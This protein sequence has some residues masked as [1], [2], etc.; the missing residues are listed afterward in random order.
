MTISG[1]ITVAEPTASTSAATK[2]Y[3]DV[4]ISVIDGGS[5]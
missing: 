3:V 4:A 2:N 5:F 1:E